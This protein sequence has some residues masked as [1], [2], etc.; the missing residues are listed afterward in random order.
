M[1]PR[2]ENTST[3]AF[4]ADSFTKGENTPRILRTLSTRLAVSAYMRVNG[5][6][7]RR[8]EVRTVER[9][10]S[11]TPTEGLSLVLRS[12]ANTWCGRLGEVPATHPPKRG[13]RWYS[14]LR[15][16]HD[17]DVKVK[18][19]RHAHHRGVAGALRCGQRT[20][21]TAEEVA[22]DP[23]TKGESLVL[24]CMVRPLAQT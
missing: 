19:Q 13:C 7:Y 24:C 18:Y 16:T 9:S 17:A 15:S 2:T 14:A 6:V 10:T 11:D 12:A 21:Q 8:P 4:G 5:S 23:A 20:V 3:C 1:Y 22:S